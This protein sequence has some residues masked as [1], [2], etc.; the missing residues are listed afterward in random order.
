M[1]HLLDQH[2]ELLVLKLEK[3]LPAMLMKVRG[4]REG[5]LDVMSECLKEILENLLTLSPLVSAG[6][7][8]WREC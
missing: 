8:I 1:M 5:K 2:L 6:R 7:L 4:S 3:L